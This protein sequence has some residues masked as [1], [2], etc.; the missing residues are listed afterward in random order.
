[1]KT[2]YWSDHAKA[3]M[4]SR[5]AEAD[6]DSALAGARPP[7]K[8]MGR[9]INQAS[10]LGVRE[11]AERNLGAR[12]SYLVNRRMNIVF[13]VAEYPTN[14]VVVTAFPVPRKGNLGG[15]GCGG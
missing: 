14:L 7:S 2:V 9:W 8:R 10:T 12:V 3:R 6:P 1:M 11:R 5:F 15:Y 4:A 13:V